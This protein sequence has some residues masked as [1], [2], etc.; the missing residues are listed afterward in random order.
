MS[1]DRHSAAASTG[2]HRRR[3]HALLIIVAAGVLAITAAYALAR[4][5][6]DDGPNGRYLIGAWTFGERT[7]LEAA[8]DAGAIDEVSVDWLQS[9]ADGSLA[10][11]KLDDE[12]I[13]L[14][15]DKGCRVVVT[16]TDYDQTTHAFDAKISAAILASEQSR[17]AHATA[18]AEWCRLHEVA[19]VDVDWEAVK[20][21]H[22][23]EFTAFVATLAEKLHADDRLI[24]V[25]VYP[26]TS[27]PGSW[28]GPQ[29]QDWRRLGEIVDQFRIMTYNYSGSWSDPGPLSPP[30]WMDRVLDFAETQVAAERI[31]AGIGFYGRDWHG[32][33]TTDWVWAN[34]IATR[35]DW[36]P[37]ERRAVSRELRLDYEK[38]GQAHV[39]FFPDALAIR[40]KLDMLRSEHPDV[41]GVYAWLM[42]QEDPAVWQELHTALR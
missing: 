17:N 36:T 27:E 41:Q 42:G 37:R 39:A 24:A 30:K 14:A 35:R 23:E 16:L 7:S 22:R 6:D 31:V 33:S 13:A 34:V 10:A 1:D 26:K 8:L 20:A 3:T 40:A 29:S 21:S 12:F 25:D 19:G 9:R 38:D 15:K 2:S 32:S 28:N 18:V 11:P 4:R 5:F